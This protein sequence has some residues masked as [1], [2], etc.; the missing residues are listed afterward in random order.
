MLAAAGE[1]MTYTYTAYVPSGMGLG[2]MMML[3]MFVLAVV[4]LDAVVRCAN[5]LLRWRTPRR[6]IGVQTDPRQPLPLPQHRRADGPVA[7]VAVAAAS[8]S[9]PSGVLLNFNLETLTV[10]QLK[11]L[12]RDRKL[13]V[14]GTKTDLV[15]R[16]TQRSE[17]ASI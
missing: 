8:S 16:L 3:L 14:G 6:S 12:C 17:P 15:S 4:G 11:G 13:L 9:T 10:E 7:A 2:D 5:R 1:L